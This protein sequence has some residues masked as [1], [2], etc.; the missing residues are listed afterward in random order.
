ML[1]VL[2]GFVTIGAVIGLGAFLAHWRIR[3]VNGQKTLVR[4]SF[5]VASPALIVTVLADTDVSQ[6]FSAN[7]VA[8]LVSV[9]VAA[10]VWVLLARL[11][12]RR[13][14]G[15]TVIGAFG[16]AYVNAGNLGLPIAAYAL[17]NASLIVPMLLT[18]ML[19]LQPAG[20]MALDLATSKVS[21]LSRRAWVWYMLTRPFRNPMTV[22][23]LLGL[24]L[25]ITGI[26][27]PPLIGDPLQLVA[28]MAVPGMLLAY[29]VSLRLGPRFG[30]GED[31]VPLAT[32]VALK[33]VGQPLVAFLI[34]RF[35]VGLEPA[36]VF[37]VTV[38]AALP[39]AQN[40]FTHAVRYNQ[41]VVLARDAIFLST[42]LAVPALILIAAFLA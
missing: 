19:I 4:L 3:D 29:G 1:G 13:S 35:V 42:V 21:D 9:V 12:W 20:L 24:F 36:D 17:G 28:N 34:A 38:I 10:S 40:V 18:Q 41:G 30:S 6:I 37:A 14:V 26:Q 11:V 27:I 33:V 15:D 39:T 23:S 2:A 16:A 31:R 22:G 25:S 5:F 32:V 8:S 7:L